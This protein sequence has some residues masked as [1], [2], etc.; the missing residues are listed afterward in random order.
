[1]SIYSVDSKIIDFGMLVESGDIPEE[2]IQD[3]FESLEGEWEQ[4]IDQTVSYI[5]NLKTQADSIK[6]EKETLAAREKT[7]RNKADR[8]MDI[9][10]QSMK[11]HGYNG[12]NKRKLET[13]RNIIKIQNN[14]ESVHIEDEIK[15]CKD[16]YLQLVGYV[17]LKPHIERAKIKEHLKAGKIVFG[18]KLVQTEGLRIK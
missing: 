18:A 16:E 4:T 17:T 5:K 2:A 12:E 13:S 11:S 15:F 14:P 1:M 7:L 8:L 3:T 9:V 6:F 10:E